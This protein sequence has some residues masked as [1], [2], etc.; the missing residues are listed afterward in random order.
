MGDIAQIEQL[1]C[2]EMSAHGGSHFVRACACVR[3]WLQ[4]RVIQGIKRADFHRR[5]QE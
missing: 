1:Q 3:A 2:S 4:R 5:L